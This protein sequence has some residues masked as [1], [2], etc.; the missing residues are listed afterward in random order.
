MLHRRQ[1]FAKVGPG[2]VSPMMEIIG[3]AP[4]ARH[5]QIWN[6]SGVQLAI[7]GSADGL[8][9]RLLATVPAGSIGNLLAFPG[10]D[11]AIGATGPSATD[12]VEPFWLVVS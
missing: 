1:R 2:A 8:T 11:F 5:L 7:F 4:G 3:E 6:P 9:I 12:A 10:G